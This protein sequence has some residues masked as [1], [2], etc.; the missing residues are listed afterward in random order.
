M[1]QVPDATGADSRRYALGAVAILVLA[2]VLRFYHLGVWSMWVDEGMT[3]L[4]AATGN[5]SDQ[6]PLYATAPLNFVVTRAIISAAGPSLFWLRFF[7]AVCGVLGVAA[8]LW[9]GYRLGGPVTSLVAG[10]LLALSPW[11]IDWS[12]NARHFSALFLFLVVVFTAFHA[13]WES[14]RAGWLL[15][16]GVG[17]A[18]ALLTHSSAVFSLA[19]IGVYS[20]VLV[21][22]RALRGTVVTRRT[23]ILVGA[24]FLVLA[25]GYLPIALSVSRY[26]GEHKVAWNSPSNVAGSILFYIGPFQLALAALWASVMIERRDRTGL[27]LL[28]WLAWPI[29]LVVLASSRTI[30][31]GAYALPSLGA[32]V[33]LIGLLAR[34]LWSAEMVGAR[35]RVFAGVLVAAVVAQ[36]GLGATLYFT[37]EQGNRPPWDQAVEWVATRATSQDEIFASEGIV[38]GYYLADVSRGR[39]LDRWH[40]PEAG[41][42]QWL[43]VLSGDGDAEQLP[44][45]D[46]VQQRCHME[47]VFFRNT[48]P[49]RRDIAAYLCPSTT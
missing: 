39:W 35:G 24:F 7:P 47:K 13:F 37:T 49:K 29:I 9:S 38:V 19:A 17:A 31:S 2:T 42:R 15:A 4:R 14:G 30:A 36:V 25:A 20:A 33:I 11:H 48:G 21:A 3:Y 34:E 41:R 44:L 26:L 6:G 28:N 27:Y 8:I 46:F 22:T 16:A 10:L 23:V 32:A 45:R 1:S 40:A 18:L 12:Q 5:L 43:L